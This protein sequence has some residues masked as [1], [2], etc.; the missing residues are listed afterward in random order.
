MKRFALVLV[1]VSCLLSAAQ[2]V[3]MPTGLVFTETKWTVET[4]GTQTTL[5]TLKVTLKNT[6]K[7]IT[8]A[9]VTVDTSI[10]YRADQ[11]KHSSST[12]SVSNL[13]PGDSWQF[14][15]IR[16]RTRK[17]EDFNKKYYARIDKVT[18]YKDGS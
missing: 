3:T 10:L 11:R 17:G 5:Y 4:E 15:A 16:C 14:V 13:Q 8:Y 9:S 2:A 12:Q 7:A 18:A 1:F 6:T